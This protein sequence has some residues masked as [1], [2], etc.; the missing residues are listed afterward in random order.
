M[1]EATTLPTEPQ[2]LPEVVATVTDTVVVIGSFAISLS[3]SF[4]ASQTVRSFLSHF[5]SLIDVSDKSQTEP[6][7]PTAKNCYFLLNSDHLNYRSL[8][9]GERTK[10]TDR[11]LLFGK[12]LPF[13]EEIL[14]K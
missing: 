7:R 13:W 14:A 3:P 4:S 5:L 6:L 8:L 9:M 1:S 11:H 10:T 12:F 2:P